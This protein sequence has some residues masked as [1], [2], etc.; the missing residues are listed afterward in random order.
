[1]PRT[2]GARSGGHEQKREALLSVLRKRLASRD[3]TRPSLRALAEAAGVTLPT[4]KHYFGSREAVVQAVFADVERSGEPH[5]ARTRQPEGSFAASIRA[6]VL[7]AAFGLRRTELGDLLAA[8]LVEGLLDGQLGP[9]CVDHL[10]EPSLSAIAARLMAHQQAGEMRPVDPRHAAIQL[11]APILLA[12]HHQNQLGGRDKHA[13]DL[14]SF[15][16]THVEAF[17]RAY[18]TP[19]S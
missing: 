11:F 16:E 4:L 14:D 3:G 18:Q 19:S 2:K 6:C 12:C 8:A 17:V 15:L 7:D 5:I 9:A 13:M 10:L 1:M